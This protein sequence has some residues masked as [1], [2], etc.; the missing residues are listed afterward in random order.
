MKR[1]III[2]TSC[3]LLLSCS[4]QK[5]VNN[6]A[7]EDF[8]I[9]KAQ[10]SKLG[11]I[12][13]KQKQN[14]SDSKIAKTRQTISE[15]KIILSELKRRGAEVRE[16][17]RGVVV[18]SADILFEFNSAE[19][20]KDAI[21]AITEIAEVVVQYPKRRI[22]VE[23]HTDSVGTMEYNQRLSE[24]RAFT[25]ANEL[26]TQGVSRRRIESYGHGESDPIASNRNDH[27]RNRNRRVEVIFNN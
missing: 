10:D 16:T 14:S 18:N 25:I 11:A 22:S 13:S 20:T 23:G 7:Q 6:T 26:V 4:S 19:I 21:I 17:E 24:D 8:I 15:N 3:V 2:L 1:S 27:G 12:V 5:T 9:N